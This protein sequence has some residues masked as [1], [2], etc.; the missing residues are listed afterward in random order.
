MP[1]IKNHVTKVILVKVALITLP[2]YICV[3]LRFEP[4]FE[5]IE[6]AVA[7]LIRVDIELDIF[8]RG[9]VLLIFFRIYA[10]LFSEEKESD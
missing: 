4:Y 6:D 8:L 7:K 2:I 5:I 1:R 10:Y 9:I 3:S